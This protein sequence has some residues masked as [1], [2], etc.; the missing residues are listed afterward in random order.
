VSGPTSETPDAGSSS[1]G[2]TWSIGADGV[3][4]ILFDSPGEKVN[5]INPDVLTA[6]GAALGY[7][8]RRG[9]IRGLV[10][11]SAKPGVFI[12][13]A[14]VRLI[15]S[16][17]TPEE[18]RGKALN[19]QIVFQAIADA[20]FPTVAAIPGACL[21][22]GLEI[23]LACGSRIAADADEVQI[24]LPEVRLGIIPGWGGTQRLPRL[25]GLPAALGI[26][27]A[28][29]TLSA[30]EAKRA[31]LVDALVPAERLRL[32]ARKMALSSMA[33]AT[34]S[35]PLKERLLLAPPLRSLVLSRA[36]SAA[37]KS[38]GGHYPAP[39]AALDA[40]GYGLAH[41]MREGLSRE[42][43][44]V[45]RLVTG[46]VSRNLVRL[47]L[48]SRGA[49]SERGGEADRGEEPQARPVRSIG[50]LGAGVMGGAIA[51]VAASKGIPVRLRDVA[52]A[53][54]ARGLGEAHRILS[55]RGSR[56]RPAAWTE[57]RFLKVAPTLGLEGFR[58]ADLVVEAVVED[59]EVKKRVL[60]E[61][62]GAVRDDCILA[63]NTSSLPV[64]AMAAALRIPGRFVGLHFFN[65]AERMPLVEVVRGPASS[66]SAIAAARAL[67]RRMGKTPIVVADSPGFVVNRLLTP[68]LAG[69]LR[70]VAEGHDVLS[71]DRTL[72]RFGMPMGP[73]ALL[74]QIGLDVAAKV[75]KV[76]SAAFSD[77]IPTDR[78]LEALAQA[79]MLGVKSGAGFYLYASGKKR[80][81]NAQAVD[82]ARRTGAA[83]G[84]SAHA[85]GSPGDRTPPASSRG[86]APGGM[87]ERLL[88]PMINEAARLLEEGAVDGPA[89]IDVA[90]VFGTGFPPFLGGPLRWADA[91]GIASIADALRDLASRHGEGLAPCARLSRMAGAGE[92]FHPV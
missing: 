69:G 22:G 72:T 39:F 42:A 76:L 41:G 66:P 1:S 18:A 2:V 25:I 45:G 80:G 63:T 79:G 86:Q 31:G 4:E 38:T 91:R 51:A 87:A 17:R 64:A 23:A 32:E 84:G 46:E 9:D 85:T 67:A 70:A 78:S 59:L 88:F 3:A 27:L 7:F 10:L 90:M 29:R 53:P 47:F 26:I 89:S 57:A 82:L 33:R 73:L 28:G 60:S 19:G 12:A 35:L 20:P 40:I 77:H 5:V 50:V 11:A 15:G 81:V 48:A 65:P 43:D 68:Y 58:E 83:G 92:T 74:D 62:E 6:L 16:V 14:D 36:G 34:R 71:I 55:G 61:I 75:S 30:R 52:P 37:R 24:G 44:H 21:G 54:L 8:M 49:E 13:G 56:K